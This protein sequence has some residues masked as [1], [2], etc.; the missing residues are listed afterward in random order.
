MK[1]VSMKWIYR[2][3]KIF[4]KIQ[5]EFIVN[6]AKKNFWYSYEKLKQRH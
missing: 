4:L 2:L 6:E 3:K 1:L 5:H